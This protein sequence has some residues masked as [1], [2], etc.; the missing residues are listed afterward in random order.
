MTH[1]RLTHFSLLK[2]V[3]LLSTT[4]F[5][6]IEQTTP[7]TWKNNLCNRKFLVRVRCKLSGPESGLMTENIRSA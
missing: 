4:I 2:C 3:N 5:R 1:Q 6:V 7:K